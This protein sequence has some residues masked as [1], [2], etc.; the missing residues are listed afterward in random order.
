MMQMELI[1][2]Q[3]STRKRLGLFLVVMGYIAIASAPSKVVQELSADM[4][5]SM[6]LPNPL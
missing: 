3:I 6:L 5:R 2:I 1:S 4:F